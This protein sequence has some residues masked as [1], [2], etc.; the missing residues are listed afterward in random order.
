MRYTYCSVDLCLTSTIFTQPI[1]DCES[2]KSASHDDVIKGLP[3][4]IWL[5]PRYRTISRI[6]NVWNPAGEEAEALANDGSHG[7]V[8]N[9]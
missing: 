7:I 8:K 3:C 2:C 9:E 4:D 5:R 6:E 1:S